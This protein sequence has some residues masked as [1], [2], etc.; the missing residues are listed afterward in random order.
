[1]ARSAQLTVVAIL[2]LICSG[3]VV[4]AGIFA[5]TAPV[6]GA[7][8][9]ISILMT[10]AAVW[11]VATGGGILR[12]WRWARISIIVF[13]AF[14]ASVGYTFGPYALFLLGPPPL[15]TETGR[16]LLAA[17]CLL[18]V[19]TGVWW[20]YLFSAGSARELFRVPVL[21]NPMPFS[22]AL[23]AWFALIG[24]AVSGTILLQLQKLPPTLMFGFLLTGWLA[25]GV[26]LVSVIVEL[27]VGLGLLLR[28]K[29][30]IRLAAFFSAFALLETAISLLRPG[31]NSRLTMY[32]DIQI[33]RSPDLM[34]YISTESW[35]HMFNLSTIESATLTLF[36]L[37]FLRIHK[38]AFAAREATN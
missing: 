2:V 20:A 8:R 10:V 23:I 18:L 32:Y 34:R 13:A 31:W 22:I 16:I 1:M 19:A 36:A 5:L 3:I 25:F 30:S 9:S 11:G 6:P 26:R 28:G 27:C 17:F 15:T 14:I 37:W 12:R 21:A 7:D 4:A 33:A 29:Y 38:D 24:A 35:R